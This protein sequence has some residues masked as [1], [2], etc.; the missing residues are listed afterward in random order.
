MA[1]AE[2]A[3]IG[4]DNQPV[5]F[6]QIGHGK[7]APLRR[8]RGGDRV[9]YYAPATTL[10]GKDRLQSFVSIG[11][12]LPGD[13]YTGNMGGGFVPWRRDVGDVPAHE[14][15]IAPLVDAFEWIQHRQHWGAKLRFGLFE[16][17]NGDMRTIAQAMN[18]N[19]DDLGL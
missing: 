4:R 9:A 10:G 17:G 12:V 19:T 18:A 14:T 2:H 15:P 16:I 11:L 3:R 5:G 1:S 7:G 13:L 8:L 6:M